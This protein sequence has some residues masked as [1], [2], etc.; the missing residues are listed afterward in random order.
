[1]RVLNPSQRM[2][3]MAYGF[4]SVEV[5]RRGAFC[6]LAKAVFNVLDI[7]TGDRYCCVLDA[8]LP[9]SDLMLTQ[10]LLLESVPERFF[11]IANRKPA[12][13]DSASES[14]HMAD[15]QPGASG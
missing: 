2:Q 6:I 13:L 8:N 3:F 7:A 1:M 14:R 11:A 12:F 5:P 10:K 15:Q 4:F 9:L